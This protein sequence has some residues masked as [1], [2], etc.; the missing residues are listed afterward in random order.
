MNVKKCSKCGIVK[1]ITEFYRHPQMADGLR[2]YC[3][4]CHII[5]TEKWRK[6]NP[7]KRKE[8]T[9]RSRYKH[10]GVK[11]MSENKNC[12]AYLGIHIAERVLSLAFNNVEIMPNNNPG[13]DFICNNGYKID[14]K[15]SVLHHRNNWAGWNFAIGKNKIA[16]YFLCIAFDNRTDLNPLHIWII[17]SNILNTQSGATISISTL[18]KWKKY[19]KDIDNV[20]TCCNVLKSDGPESVSISS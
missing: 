16:D 3:K 12:S 10:H 4:S 1:P 14:V 19:E 17:P 11:P 13:Y 20:I 6:C 7:E 15:S 18:D 2:S 5:D 9:S 8:Y